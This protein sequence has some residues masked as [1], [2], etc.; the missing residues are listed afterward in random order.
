LEETVKSTTLSKVLDGIAHIA[1]MKMDLEGVEY[2]ALL[3][4]GYALS[5]ITNIVF[6]QLEPEDTERQAARHL[7]DIGFSILSI[8]G[9]NKIAVRNNEKI[10]NGENS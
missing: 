2:E 7:K 4:A 5:K 10:L 6:E 3:G 1:L 8:D 9:R